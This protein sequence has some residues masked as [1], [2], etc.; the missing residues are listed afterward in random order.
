M[1]ACEHKLYI[2]PEIVGQFGEGVDD[3]ND[4]LAPIQSAD[5]EHEFR[6]GEPLHSFLLC[7]AIDLEIRLILP[8]KY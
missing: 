7:R 2:A 3:C 4:I 8:Q 5:I 6:I 1:I